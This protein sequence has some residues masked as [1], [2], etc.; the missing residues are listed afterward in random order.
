MLYNQC[1]NPLKRTRRGV[2]FLAPPVSSSVRFVLGVFGHHIGTQSS[3]PNF[4]GSLWA[5]PSVDVWLN[6]LNHTNRFWSSPGWILVRWGILFTLTAGGFNVL[7]HQCTQH[8]AKKDSQFFLDITW[9]N[10]FFFHC[11]AS[12]LMHYTIKLMLYGVLKTVKCHIRD[13]KKTTLCDILPSKNDDRPPPQT[14]EIL[15]Y[16]PFQT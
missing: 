5:E 16:R 13:V 12:G 2:I 15:I 7:V 1:F 6:G 4:S 9:Q 14:S 3:L 10:M 8:K 11:N